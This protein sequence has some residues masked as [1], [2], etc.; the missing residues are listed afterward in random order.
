[1]STSKQRGESMF[2]LDFDRLRTGDSYRSTP[3]PIEARDVAVFAALT[4]D[5]HPIHVDPE[6]AAAGP[7]GRPIAHGMLILSCAVGV[8]PL[9]PDRIVALRRIRD[10]VFKRPLAVGEAIVV[11]SRITGLR[12]LD[13]GSGLVECEWRI[14]GDDGRLRSRAVVEIVWRRDGEGEGEPTMSRT[15]VT[16]FQPRPGGA[17][18]ADELAPVEVSDDGLRVLV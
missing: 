12:P 7:F 2:G 15:A 17:G 18:E 6:Y 4:G 13:E 9:D 8:L 3:C 1:M 16:S 14:L 10:A 11:D 5:G